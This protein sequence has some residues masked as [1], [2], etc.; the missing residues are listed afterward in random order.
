MEEDVRDPLMVR[1]G[2]AVATHFLQL[3]SLT[4]SL[5]QSI[6]KSLSEL[7]CVGFHLYHLPNATPLP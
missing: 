5:F 7:Y 1:S 3:L 4:P 6:E 2:I